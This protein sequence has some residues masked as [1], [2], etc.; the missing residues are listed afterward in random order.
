[1]RRNDMERLQ[2]SQQAERFIRLLLEE[3]RQK[4]ARECRNLL[5]QID[6][7]ERQLETVGRELRGL[8]EQL[9]K[10][11]RGTPERN[12]KTVARRVEREVKEAKK[13]IQEIKDSI[14]AGMGKAV[15][16][17]KRKGSEAL[18]G[19]IDKLHVRVALRNISRGM[20]R[21]A[22][23][24]QETIDRIRV[25]SEESQQT[26]IHKRNVSRVLMGKERETV[27][28]E[29]QLGIAARSAIR[30]FET[31]KGLCEG[32]RKQADVLEE[33]IVRMS[34]HIEMDRGEENSQETQSQEQQEFQGS[35]VREWRRFYEP[36]EPEKQ[37]IHEP[38]GARGEINQGRLCVRP[39]MKKQQEARAEQVQRRET[40]QS[41]REYKR[42]RKQKAPSENHAKRGR[43]GMEL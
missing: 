31:V 36:Q 29:F 15:R 20:E 37:G 4:E 38:G 8:K 27:P 35:Q 40:I 24:M 28:E 11:G 25:A 5:E 26:K 7:L 13:Q 23:K 21:A 43:E 19:V 1:M 34:R 6:D 32:I 39:E 33:K 2:D 14:L 10:A 41:I 22:I 12:L 30:P 16:D 18:D 42:S 3:E 17:F 9:G